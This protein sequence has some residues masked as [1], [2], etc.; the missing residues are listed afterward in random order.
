MSVNNQGSI[1]SLPLLSGESIHAKR[2]L[3]T[4]RGEEIAGFTECFT[5]ELE[6]AGAVTRL[7]VQR[8]GLKYIMKLKFDMLACSGFFFSE[9]FI[10]MAS[11]IGV[12]K[13]QLRQNRNCN[14]F[15]PALAPQQKMMEA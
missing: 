10:K 2:E 4:T 7:V 5:V 9:S 3:V 14:L 1:T 12:N 8:N 11:S 13:M 15:R 6:G